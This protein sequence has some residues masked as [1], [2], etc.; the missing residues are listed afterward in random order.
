MTTERYETVKL[1]RK[2]RPPKLQKLDLS[3]VIN[4]YDKDS[5]TDND[6][7]DR[8]GTSTD[9]ETLSSNNYL[10]NVVNKTLSSYNHV[11]FPELPY[12]TAVNTTPSSMQ[13]SKD[14]LIHIPEEKSESSCHNIH[15]HHKNEVVCTCTIPKSSISSIDELYEK[16][17][18]KKQSVP[19]TYAKNFLSRFKSP[20][21][22][23][24][25]VISAD[26][27]MNTP[28]ITKLYSSTTLPPKSLVKPFKP[29][30][31]DPLPMRPIRHNSEALAK[32]SFYDEFTY[33]NSGSNV[34][35]EEHNFMLNDFLRNSN[36]N[37]NILDTRYNLLST[38]NYN[39]VCKLLAEKIEI[40]KAEFYDSKHVVIY[41]F[42]QCIARKN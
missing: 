13:R 9:L 31:P 25:S 40:E 6:T 3:N 28:Y 39:Q 16:L 26:E 32:K 1:L 7:T 11:V 18:K 19:N 33:E 17:E 2:P 20:M 30:G 5:S 15:H 10:V 35:N 23:I 37:Q 22:T 42:I 12:N 24:K 38:Y 4:P 14:K 29:P 21:P 27:K 34:T 36:V 8:S 41:F